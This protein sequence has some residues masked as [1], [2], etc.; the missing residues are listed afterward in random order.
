MRGDGA[1]RGLALSSAL[2]GC[3]REVQLLLGWEQGGR[4]GLPRAADGGGR[5]GAR[6]VVPSASAAELIML[7]LADAADAALPLSAASVLPSQSPAAAELYAAVSGTAWGGVPVSALVLPLVRLCRDGGETDPAAPRL[8]ALGATLKR[9]AALRI[10][11]TLV[12]AS[13][14]CRAVFQGSPMAQSWLSSNAPD[15]TARSATPALAAA[16]LAA[17]STRLSVGGVSWDAKA[18]AVSARLA[19][20]L[21][22]ERLPRL[23]PSQAARGQGEGVA[24][25]DGDEEQSISLLPTATVTSLGALF[26][27]SALPASA[28]A[29]F[30]LAPFASG[31][32]MAPP[33]PGPQAPATAERLRGE[34][35]DA[36]VLICAA[37]G[38]ETLERLRLVLALVEP[39]PAAVPDAIVPAVLENATRAR[40]AADV[41]L[42]G[43]PLA[44]LAEAADGVAALLAARGLG[45]SLPGIVQ[46]VSS[47]ASAAPPA[48]RAKSGGGGSVAVL[49]PADTPRAFAACVAA[50]RRASAAVAIV[51]HCIVLPVTLHPPPLAATAALRRRSAGVWSGDC[52]LFQVLRAIA[53]ATPALTTCIAPAAVA[54]G[55]TVDGRPPGAAYLLRL[56]LAAACAACQL[57]CFDALGL[58]LSA[59][60][61]ATLFAFAGATA[62]LRQMLTGP[63]AADATTDASSLSTDAVDA[64]MLLLLPRI[65]AALRLRILELVH[66]ASAA[67]GGPESILLPRTPDVASAVAVSQSDA[68][69]ALEADVA[70]AEGVH[71]RTVLR[72]CVSASRLLLRVPGLASLVDSTVLHA[73]AAFGGGGLQR[74][75]AASSSAS[76]Q[77]ASGTPSAWELSPGV[78]VPGLAAALAALG[79][80]GAPLLSLAPDLAALSAQLRAELQQH[81]R[82]QRRQHPAPA[83]SGPDSAAAAGVPGHAKRSDSTDGTRDNSRPP[84]PADFPGMNS[85]S[86][87]DGAGAA[88][89]RAAGAGGG[90][91]GSA[92]KAARL[93]GAAPSPRPPAASRKR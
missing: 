12:L 58:A 36:E 81:L 48:R 20:A 68:A 87:P 29:L 67:R 32:N 21:P 82:P 74:G 38:E 84:P 93:T 78:H 1:A 69:A 56:R 73:A 24:A 51:S 80:A 39:W 10:L 91:G 11:R 52:F 46:M 3:A 34:A 55:A 26:P 22:V 27:G 60:G 2:A 31:G 65:V 75:A 71:A 28:L 59:H 19:A 89:Q 53:L 15:R 42:D 90:G 66:L 16:G 54:F 33:A 61:Q 37:A 64:D 72:V 14:S 88:A 4:G 44:T 18:R 79:Q 13:P 7:G 25:A 45:G 86:V 35:R 63:G 70:V 92:R 83:E 8:H 17:S 85:G 6:S 41:A 9:L 40:V 76:R 77:G 43:F 47:A 50:L 5:S 57:R 23:L 30:G 62:Q 49:T